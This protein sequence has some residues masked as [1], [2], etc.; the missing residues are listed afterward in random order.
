MREQVGLS[1]IQTGDDAEQG[2][3]RGISHR[4][5]TSG[6]APTAQA[7]LKPPRLGCPCPGGRSWTDK[8]R[9]DSGPTPL[10]DAPPCSVLPS[11]GGPTTG[12]TGRRGPPPGRARAPGISLPPGSPLQARRWQAG[13][14]P[15]PQGTPDT[16]RATTVGGSGE[17]LRQSDVSSHQ[18]V[19]KRS[20]RRVGNSLIQHLLL[21]VPMRGR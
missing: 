2:P 17:D 15:R 20:G 10:S 18:G 12:R 9:Q 4:Q 16:L 21:H 5:T 13:H 19:L 8:H 7:E 1:M 14:P 6:P 11:W 3:E